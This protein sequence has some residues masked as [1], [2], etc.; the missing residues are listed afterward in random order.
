M[1]DALEDPESTLQG[2]R[3]VTPYE[4]VAKHF[5][6]NGV[7]LDP[8]HVLP[9]DELLKNEAC[10]Q[11]LLDAWLPQDGFRRAPIKLNMKV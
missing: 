11:E 6:A 5:G 8:V 7:V 4:A 9:I 2:G 10:T 3:S 1:I